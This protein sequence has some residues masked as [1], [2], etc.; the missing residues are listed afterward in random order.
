[1]PGG[2]GGAGDHA[3][4]FLGRLSPAGSGVPIAFVAKC[5]QALDYLASEI[6]EVPLLV[7][8]IDHNTSGK[9]GKP[10]RNAAA[11]LQG[12]EIRAK[13]FK[14]LLPTYDVFDERRYFEPAEA[15]EP[16]AWKGKRL[17]IT[18][19]EDI[20]TE[21]QH[22]RPVYD[23]DPVRGT[24]RQGHRPAAESLRLSFP[25]RQAG[26]AARH[27]RIAR[28]AGD[29]GSLC[30]C[31]GRE[32]SLV[33]DGHSLSAIRQRPRD[34]QMPGFSEACTT[35]DCGALGDEEAHLPPPGTSNFTKHS[36]WAC[37]T[38]PPSAASAAPAW[39]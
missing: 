8:Y 16:I 20:W 2:R 15:C 3:G 10:F 35:I 9:P 4:T 26:T 11:F 5:L 25:S 14:T 36:C 13:I 12:G 38:M 17:G 30:E 21:D 6:K 34:V 37:A 23:R 32:Y 31:S 33:F 19:C 18:I 22:E 28:E 24:S 7:G 1:M 27:A 29:A 39:V